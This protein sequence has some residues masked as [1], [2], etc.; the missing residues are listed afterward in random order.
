MFKL[1][2]DVLKS[3]FE[4]LNYPYKYFIVVT[5]SCNSKCRFCKIWTEQPQNE[6]SVQEYEKLAQNSPF[7]KWLNISGGEPTNREDLKDIIQVFASNCPQLKMINFTTNGIDPDKIMNQVDAIAQLTNKKLV[8]NVSLDGST[9]LHEKLRGVKGN[10]ESAL[11]TFKR[12]RQHKHIDSYLAFTF[13]G[14]NNDQLFNTFDEVKK[15]IPHISTN[16][17]HLNLPQNSEHFYGNQT[18][19]TNFDEKVIETI[20]KFESIEGFQLNTLK[21]FEKTYRAH[22]ID[23]YRTKKMPMRCSALL[24]SIYI[25][26]HG[27]IYPCTIWNKKIASLREHDFNIKWIIEQEHYKSTR[28]LVKKEQCPTCWTPCEAFHTIA[29]NL[30][31][32]R[33]A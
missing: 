8:I 13:Y 5:K 15:T 20:R 17:F 9:E 30:H 22:A 31:K 24:S 16:D 32:I 11:E 25:S 27:D 1:A 2:V 26:E 19:K 4:L 14:P 28:E 3:N 12:I 6:L 33:L 29:A 21:A 7:L 23:F 10:F 18:V